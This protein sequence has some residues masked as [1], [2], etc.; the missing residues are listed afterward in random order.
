MIITLFVCASIVAS[1]FII[2]HIID[3]MHKREI[4]TKQF[5][6]SAQ[7]DIEEIYYII[8]SCL[9]QI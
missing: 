6:E 7:R 3:K 2:C 9:Q 4:D 5:T 1:I 8:N